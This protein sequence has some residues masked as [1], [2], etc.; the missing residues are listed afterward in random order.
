MWSAKR[1]A[2][3][4]ECECDIVHKWHCSKHCGWYFADEA[5]TKNYHIENKKFFELMK[6]YPRE[7]NR[8]EPLET[9]N[10]FALSNLKKNYH[11]DYEA[12]A[13]P[14]EYCNCKHYSW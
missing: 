4:T 1:A 13:K 11:W 9:M 3:N 10:Y 7:G 12:A 5:K 14:M 6:K 2:L 8:K